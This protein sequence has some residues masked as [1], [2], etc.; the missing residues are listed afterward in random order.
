MNSKIK[1]AIIFVVYAFLVF[2]FSVL[3]FIFFSDASNVLP[4]DEF[5]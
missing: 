1:A 4:P 5:A 2:L 3:W